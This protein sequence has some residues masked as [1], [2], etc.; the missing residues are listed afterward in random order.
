MLPTRAST[1]TASVLFAAGVSVCAAGLL[2]ATSLRTPALAL[3]PILPQPPASQQMPPDEEP[4]AALPMPPPRPKCIADTSGFR[5]DNSYTIEIANA[6]EMAFRCTVH[7]YIVN[8]RGPVKAAVSFKLAPQ[9]QGTSAKRT[10]V[11]K[12]KEFGGSADTSRR[13]VPV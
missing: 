13:C 8:S 4:A 9:S 12:L 3:K 6:C 10:H 1:F 11:I 2:L 5:N 7:A